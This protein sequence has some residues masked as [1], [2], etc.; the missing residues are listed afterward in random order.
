[1]VSKAGG[2]YVPLDQITQQPLAYIVENAQLATVL[3]TEALKTELDLLADKGVCFEQLNL[4]EES[5]KAPVTRSKTV[6]TFM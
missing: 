1:M 3:T 6:L 4:A 5:T 2:A